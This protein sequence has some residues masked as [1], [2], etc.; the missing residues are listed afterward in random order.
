MKPII[1]PRVHTFLKQV[2]SVCLYIYINNIYIYIHTYIH[3][4]IHIHIY[5]YIVLYVQLYMS[6]KRNLGRESVG[7]ASC[8]QVSRG[9][10]SSNS[11]AHS[12]EPQVS[13]QDG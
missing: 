13:E 1:G 11:R 8:K 2:G 9:R 12:R 4:Y 10:R 3:T 6:L 7:A 5:I